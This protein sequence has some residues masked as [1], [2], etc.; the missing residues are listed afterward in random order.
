MTMRRRSGWAGAD[1]NRRPPDYQSGAPFLRPF[2]DIFFSPKG[3]FFFEKKRGFTRLS[4]Q[5]FRGLIEYCFYKS[6]EFI[7]QMIITHAD[8]YWI[9]ILPS[10]RRPS[11][12]ASRE[13]M[14]EHNGKWVVTGSKNYIQDLAFRI[15][16]VVE[17]GKIDV[18]KFTK[19]YPATDPL[20]H[21]KDYAMCVYSDSRAKDKTAAVLHSLGITEL[22]WV[23]D[24]ESIEDW[25]PG[26]RL[27][28]EA[29]KAGRKVD[30]HT[31]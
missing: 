18:A 12:Y 9:W 3:L 31:Y 21:V 14:L 15:D 8:P 16:A 22:R 13:E 6:S 20:P 7:V 28:T 26:G 24:R 27:A 1:L 4:Y 23:Y 19:K 17:E 25:S 5:P 2:L 11:T 29:A 10:N 30:P